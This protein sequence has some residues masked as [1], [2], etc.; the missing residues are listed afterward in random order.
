M[1][2]IK[3][4]ANYSEV[5]PSPPS[6]TL[7]RIAEWLQGKQCPQQPAPRRVSSVT[8]SHHL[9]APPLPAAVFTRAIN[10][11]LVSIDP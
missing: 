8:H 3:T 5:L 10:E 2:I 11:H 9:L 7:S 4:F 6:A 1:D